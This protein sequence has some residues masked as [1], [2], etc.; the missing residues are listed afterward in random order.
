[1]AKVLID[2]YN[3]IRQ[4]PTLGASFEADPETARRELIELLAPYQRKRRHAVTVVF[5]GA[6]SLHL[7]ADS[8]RQAGVKVVFSAQG[9]TADE[10]IARRAQKLH[11][12]TVVVTSDQELARACRRAGAEVLSSPEFEAHLYQVLTDTGRSDE[13]ED[14]PRSRPDTRKKGPARRA[15]KRDRQRQ[16]HLEKL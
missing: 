4:S 7:A 1:M 16:R 15:K 13:E 12:G 9:Q 14:A 10:E 8:S 5:D 11:E 3:L 2:G 6:G